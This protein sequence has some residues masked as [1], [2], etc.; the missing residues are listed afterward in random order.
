[1]NGILNWFSKDKKDDAIHKNIRVKHTHRPRSNSSSETFPVKRSAENTEEEN[2]KNYTENIN[3]NNTEEITEE[4]KPLEINPKEIKLSD[5]LIEHWSKKQKMDNTHSDDFESN[6]WSSESDPTLDKIDLESQNQSQNQFHIE[7]CELNLREYKLCSNCLNQNYSCNIFCTECGTRF[8]KP[9]KSDQIHENGDYLNDS[10]IKEWVWNED[11]QIWVDNWKWGEDEM[12]NDWTDTWKWSDNYVPFDYESLSNTPVIPLEYPTSP[13]IPPAPPVIPLAPPAPPVIPLAPPAPP[14]IPL[15]PPAPPVIPLAPPAPPVIPLIPDRKSKIPLNIDIDIP[16]P[17]IPVPI[18]PKIPDPIV[19]TNTA[20]LLNIKTMNK[21]NI[22]IPVIDW[23]EYTTFENKNTFEND[24]KDYED[25]NDFRIDIGMSNE[26]PET[27]EYLLSESDSSSSEEYIIVKP[28]VKN[29][30]TFNKT[31]T[32]K[33]KSIEEID[34]TEQEEFEEEE[35]DVSESTETSEYASI[36]DSFDSS[37]ETGE[38]YLELC[39]GPMYS[40]KSTAIML[41]ITQMADI[42]FNVLYINHSDDIRTTEGQD[43]IA[44]SHNSQYKTLSKKVKGIKVSKLS[45]IDVREYDYIAV[46]E[47]QFFTDLYDTVIHWVTQYGKNVSIA[48]LDGDAYRRRFGQVLDLVPHADK[49]TKYTAYCDICR[50]RFRRVRPAPFTAR[51]AKD[52]SSISKMVG[53]RDL[54]RAMCRECHDN[55]LT[56]DIV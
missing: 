5:E 30:I 27:R 38:G 45:G 29:D 10:D 32:D 17:K 25:F 48:S 43:N 16:S 39:I 21:N 6:D 1:M 46:D 3:E 24:F 26:D 33:M 35:F 9:R 8:S 4:N 47:G 13:V 55:H 42:G 36:T 11:E 54:Y 53:G 15:A 51:L 12:D 7:S 56:K 22:D 18:V 37:D 50:D 34:V 40:G 19:P 44:T 41:K 23:S 52:T 14:V 20:K 49:V 28:L 31:S 2:P